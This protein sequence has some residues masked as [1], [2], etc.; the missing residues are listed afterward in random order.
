[1]K[2]VKTLNVNKLFSH[3]VKEIRFTLRNYPE[4]VMTKAE[5]AALDPLVLAY[6]REN[7][8]DLMGRY[9]L[10][11]ES[12]REALVSETIEAMRSKYTN[13]PRDNQ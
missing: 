12:A 2:D 3:F 13:K 6:I 7:Q 11:T 8:E 5:A 10:S 9:A 1:M 4:S